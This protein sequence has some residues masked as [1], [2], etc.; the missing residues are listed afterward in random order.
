MNAH[1]DTP[2]PNDDDGTMS[3]GFASSQHHPFSIEFDELEPPRP[4]RMLRPTLPVTNKT[5]S[6]EQKDI[7]P[8]DEFF[9]QLDKFAVNLSALANEGKL[10]VAYGR[11]AE[12]ESVLRALSSPGE[13]YPILVG[14]PRGGK[15]TLAHHVVNRIMRGECPPPIKHV[16]VYEI[17]PSRLVNLLGGN[18]QWSGKISDFYNQLVESG[19][20][21][22]IRDFHT[23]LGMGARNDSDDVDLSAGLAELM[24]TARPRLLFEGRA[25]QIERLLTERPALK[26]LFATIKVEGMKRDEAM[27]V[28]QRAVEDLEIVHEVHIGEDARDEAV[29][30]AT[31]FQVNELLPGSA[32]DM[33]KDVLAMSGDAAKKISRDTVR[34]RF[35][36]KSGLPEF[37]V[38][39]EAAYDENATRA[40]LTQRVYGQDAAVEAVLR[41]NALVRARLNNPLRPMGVFLFLGPTGVG[42]T[43]LVKALA[44]FLYGESERIVRLNMADYSYPS[45]VFGVFGN[46]YGDTEAD[47]QGILTTRLAPQPFSVLLLDEFEKAYPAMFQ[48][49][50]QLFDEGMLINGQGEELN[51]RNT[52][53]V[54]TSNLGAQLLN[55]RL[56]FKTLDVI[57][58]AERTIIKESESYFRPEFINRLDAVCFFK[59]LSRQ[60]IRQIAKREINEVVSREGITRLGLKIGVDDAVIDVLVER[61][62]DLRFGA[63]YLKRQ[64]ERGLTYP[65]ARQ[66][67]RKRI[68]KGATIRLVVRD[69]E[70]VVN[71]IEPGE[72]SDFADDVVSHPSDQTLSAKD[73]RAKLETIKPRL[74]RLMEQHQIDELKSR[75]AMMMDRIAE[76]DFWRDNREATT[77]IEQMNALSQRVDHAEN[78]LRLFEQCTRALDILPVAR[79]KSKGMPGALLEA[80]RAWHE[81][82][83]ELPLT[84]T[85]LCLR[86]TED[87]A[88]A[89]VTLRAI[90]EGAANEW[91][92]D[93]VN[94]YVDWAKH[95]GFQVTLLNEVPTG[96]N[97]VSQATI[98]VAG[99]GAYALLKGENGAH[100][101][102]R[103]PKDKRH[104][105]KVSVWAQVEVM[106]DVPLSPSA[107]R[108]VLRNVKIESKPVRENGVLTDKITRLVTITAGNRVLQWRNHL[109]IE[110]LDDHVPRYLHALQSSHQP[111]TISYQ[112]P[113]GDETV[114][115]AN[116]VRVYSIFKQQSVRDL[117]TNVTHNQPKKVLAGALDEFLL[118]YLEMSVS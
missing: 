56:G 11:D 79:G 44:K 69:G 93:M 46:P 45:A 23:A 108:E 77:Q 19:V 67:A 83:R 29:E 14:G 24:Q 32:L 95:R 65:L 3:P 110:D 62:Y 40:M 55:S 74:E 34:N 98:H 31:R 52:I 91:A 113:N 107:T 27:S 8:L 106:P 36:Q 63:R 5:M 82:E 64:I 112:S 1:N 97:G 58:E 84:E 13:L 88:G 72:T 75:V 61:G 109:N 43:E 21:L 99:Y 81:L 114:Q 118:A 66:I 48:R 26:N 73:L 9:K 50:L 28:I 96:A 30:L 42:K 100:R 60:V 51:M 90:G 25:H 80:N 12:V 59:P 53:I 2:L 17:T 102:V 94:M 86:K 101:L 15:T 54:M 57:E 22:F 78:L 18:G 76:P 115:F 89:F 68:E 105:E 6:E 16:R 20:M 39:D 37:F 117:R 70:I 7:N 71:I 10:T 111:S 85:L 49:F 41:M 4:W 116:Q 47:R 33:L 35:K 87:Q 38:S 104:S 92:H 103:P